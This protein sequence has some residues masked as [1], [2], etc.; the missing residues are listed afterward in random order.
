MLPRGQAGG[1][2]GDLDPSSKGQPG[3]EGRRR[4]SQGSALTKVGGDGEIAGMWKTPKMGFGWGPWRA[5][6]GFRVREGHSQVWELERIFW[7]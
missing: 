6:E 2:G 5:M 3:R 4:L 7:D 1:Q